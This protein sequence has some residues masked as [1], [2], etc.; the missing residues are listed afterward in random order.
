MRKTIIFSAFVSILA[1]TQLF[2]SC[3]S[4]DGNYDYKELNTLAIS[5]VE[6]Q[7]E[8]EQFSTLEITPAITGSQSFSPGGYDF[9]WCLYREGNFIENTMDTLSHEMALKAEIAYAPGSDYSL[10][11]QVK[12]KS[13]GVATILR[14]SLTVV[15]SYSKGVAI[16]SDVDGMAVVSFINSLDKVTPNAYEAVNGRP[17]GYGPIGIFH[18]GHNGNCRQQLFISTEDSC[19]VVSN[20]GFNYEMNFNDLFYFPSK[21]GRLQALSQGTDG[22][23]E[24]CIVDGKVFMRSCW[25]FSGE[26]ALP[27]FATRLACKNGG[28]VA[29]FGFS[30]DN[31]TAYFY[32]IDNRQFVYDNYDSLMP[33]S[34]GYGNGYFDPLNVGMDMVWGEN[35]VSTDGQSYVKTVMRDDAGNVYVLS[36]LKQ[37]KF[38]YDTYE[39]WYYIVPTGKLQLTG[40]A[41]SATCYAM[42]DIDV[43]FLYYATGNT[44]TC[45]STITGNI[46]S[47]ITLDGGNIDRLEFDQNDAS[48][49]YVGLSDGSR[50]P[51]S[52]TVYYLSMST[53]GQLS[54]EK[55]FEGICGKVV[56]F[57][58]NYGDND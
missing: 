21:P 57:Q 47:T 28:L 2:M 15:N 55:K 14:T 19:V 10:V 32:D 4:D 5:G 37:Y 40:E 46:V 17:L 24:Y 30:T 13:T 20:I 26:P 51:N 7:Y 44:I 43:N 12:D 16:L 23:Y 29:P 54:V 18:G 42:S 8:V 35:L 34:E 1:T 27:L 9:L 48:K 11:F 22:Y 39:S 53:N 52:G 49:M 33:L 41:S 58:V 3:A 6:K 36:G 25:V 50:K 45:V 56:D 38:D 31:L